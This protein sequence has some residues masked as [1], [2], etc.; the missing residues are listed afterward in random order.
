MLMKSNK[1]L[2]RSQP[3]CWLYNIPIYLSACFISI[4]FYFFFY[5]SWDLLVARL[6]PPMSQFHLL[7]QDPL[8]VP[9]KHSIAGKV[10]CI[11]GKNTRPTVSHTTLKASPGGPALQSG[12]G[13]MGRSLCRHYKILCHMPTQTHKLNQLFII[14]HEDNAKLKLQLHA[15]TQLQKWFK[16]TPHSLHG[17]REYVRNQYLISWNLNHTVT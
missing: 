10:H 4:L 3:L 15:T 16:W 5:S 14:T 8:T 6:Y 9:G 2:F 17:V 11:P 7:T 12:K 13:W 1:F